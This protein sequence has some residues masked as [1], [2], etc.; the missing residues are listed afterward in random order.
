MT[1]KT[2][3]FSSK[4]IIIITL[5]N[6]ILSPTV[7]ADDDGYPMMPGYGMGMGHMGMDRMGMGSMG[8]GCMGAGMMG[9]GY[10]GMHTPYYHLL[11]LTDKQRNAMRDLQ[12]NSRT[13]VLDLQDKIVDNYDQLYSLYGQGKTDVKKVGEA[14]QQIFDLRRKLI[15]IQL[16]IRNQQYDL[17]TKEQ[18]EKLKTLTSNRMGGYGPYMN[19]QGMM[20]H[21]MR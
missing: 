16:T 10:M 14:Y 21:M 1:I 17:L 18:Q 2:T 19:R 7:F 4:A 12:K 6:L 20:P 9:M 8:T 15:E 13:D 3:Y 11:D 5:L